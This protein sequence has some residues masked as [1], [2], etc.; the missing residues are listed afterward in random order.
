M[1]FLSTTALILLGATALQAQE[2]C[3]IAGPASVRI[4]SND[5]EALRAVNTAAMACATADVTVE[6]NATTEHANIQ[7]PALTAEP[8]QYTVAVVANDSIVALLNEG[9]IRPLDDLVAQYG[10]SLQ[11]SQ[12]IKIDGQT[13]AIAFM[14]NAQHLAYRRDILE[15]AGIAEPPT[16]YEDVLAAAEA[17]RS[18]GIMETP[19]V[20]NNKVGWDLAEE[21]VNMYL[22]F[23]GD[24]FEPGTPNLAL[25]PAKAV[26]A[27]EMMRSLAAY[28]P[29]D[30][31]TF[32]S[33]ASSAVFSQGQAA[34]TN[35]WGSRTGSFLDETV[36]N[37]EVV[38][39]TVLA[40][41]PTV[42][43]GTIP[44]STIWW[45]GFSIAQNI[46]DEDAAASFQAMVQ[47]M[48]AGSDPANADLAAWLVEGYQP[49][50]AVVGV[51]QTAQAGA[52]PYP[53]VPWMGI[54]HTALGDE[55][56][57]FMQGNES[58]EQALS[59]VAAAYEAAARSQGFL[60]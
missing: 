58:A 49:T 9:L 32:D 39:N 47:G 19:F 59:D 13:M 45:D 55:L 35:M 15:R 22:G 14:A 27:L 42:G 41:A 24:F 26:P 48:T 11:P 30:N 3:G 44:A 2:G 29:A 34:L 53:M 12:L 7:V 10:Q 56:A 1:K 8:A 18:Q 16:S 36:S 21:F 23:G 52:K 40:T 25:D 17:I 5:F 37:P 57:D 50:P 6:A 31:L 51:I 43:G 46:S 28:A 60:Q 20:V 4:L 38:A 54:L 33:T